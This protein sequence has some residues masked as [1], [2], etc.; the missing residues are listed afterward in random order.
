MI[1]G[2][3]KDKYDDRDYVFEALGTPPVS[4][5]DWE[6]GFDIEEKLGFK[7]FPKDQ[8][9][10]YSCVGQSNAIYSAVKKVINRLYNDVSAKSIYSL[11]A[12]GNNQ[13]AYLRDGAKSLAD[14][15]AL[16][17][18]KLPSFDNNGFATETWLTNKDWFTE[19]IKKEMK[20]LKA[21]DYFRVTTWTIDGFAKAIRDG[22]GMVAGV[23]GNNNG[24]WFSTYPQPPLLTT[25][26]G[27]LWGHAIYFGKFRIRNG[28]KELGFLNSWGEQVGEKG[29]QWIG[30]E[31]FA[32]NGRWLFNPWLIIYNNNMSNNETMRVLKDK[33]SSAVGVW[34]PAISEDVL[35]SYCLNMGREV[36]YTSDGKIDWEKTIDGQFQLN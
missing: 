19:D 29:W 6:K 25:P 33:N 14:I 9:Q 10:S 5:V 23:V 1:T 20:A 3:K 15:G 30:E 32:E 13:G 7:L 16:L 27:Q 12:L 2:A 22:D 28:K 35:K 31:W 21:D 18:K 34:L 11:I 8:Q 4:D 24:T 36:K 17:E 26:Q